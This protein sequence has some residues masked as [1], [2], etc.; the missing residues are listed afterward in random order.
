MVHYH[1]NI[2]FWFGCNGSRNVTG[3]IDLRS[4]GNRRILK[5]NKEQIE[6]LR[7]DDISS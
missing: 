1:I 5:G 2:V 4:W 3:T 7:I 6:H